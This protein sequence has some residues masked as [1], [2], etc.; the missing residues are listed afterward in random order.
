MNQ[1]TTWLQKQIQRITKY[2]WPFLGPEIT[3]DA[4][5]SEHVRPSVRISMRRGSSLD[6][7]VQM[8]LILLITLNSLSTKITL[9]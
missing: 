8:F 6:R 9:K 5:H 2:A 1:Y 4:C 3:Y 7:V